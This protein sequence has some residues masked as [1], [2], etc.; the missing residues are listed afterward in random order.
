M[1]AA[2]TLEAAGDALACSVLYEHY[3]RLELKRG[4]LAAAVAHANRCLTEGAA[5]YAGQDPGDRQGQAHAVRTFGRA[6]R[7]AG[8]VAAAGGR[9]ADATALLDQA[10]DVL[11]HAEYAETQAEIEFDYGELLLTWGE[12]AAASAHFRRAYAYR[13]RHG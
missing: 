11:R 6:L 12:P 4:R 7:T 5:G 10:L 9:R 2:E 13:Q 1:P 3:A 8:L